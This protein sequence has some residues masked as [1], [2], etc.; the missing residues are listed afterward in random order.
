MTPEEAKKILELSGGEEKKII[1]KNYRRLMRKYHPDVVR[2]HGP[3]HLQRVRK[4]IEAYQLLMHEKKEKVESGRQKAKWK[5]TGQ[6]NEKAF[7]ERNIYLFYSLEI[8]EAPYYQVAKGKYFWDPEE[9]E[10]S[11]FLLSLR[12][13]SKE[14]LEQVEEEQGYSLPEF[15]VKEK[16]FRTQA[17]L[18]SLLA[19][20]FLK[21]LAVLEKMAIPAWVDE[22]GRVVYRFRAWISGR[23][24]RIPRKGDVLYPLG[25]QG[26][27]I[28]VKDREGNPLGPLSFDEDDLYFCT[29]PLLKKKQAQVKMRVRDV[30]KEG[31]TEVEFY[32]RPEKPGKEET[33]E[34]LNEEIRSVL[35]RYGAEL[36]NL[37]E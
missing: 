3:E 14:L 35:T 16:R 34:E 2:E 29:I 9:E 5:W 20:Q 22:S 31:K 28:L 24:Q 12:H 37:R 11:L 25:F 32:F 23:G 1:R 18:I 36:G 15:L 19:Q 27:Q 33:W 30:R 4:L 17:M 6:V 13:V 21:P 26:N 10:F 7:C 8:E